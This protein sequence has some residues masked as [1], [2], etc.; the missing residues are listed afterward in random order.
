MVNKKGF[1]RIVEAS[2]AIILIFSVLIIVRAQRETRTAGK[3]ISYLVS[4]LLEE[5]GEN[6]NFRQKILDYNTSEDYSDPENAQII[7]ELRS[8]VE[9]RIEVYNLEHAVRIC[10]LNKICSLEPYPIDK[11]IFAGERVVAATLNSIEFSPRKIKIFLWK[12]N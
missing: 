11:E 1:I 9:P 12:K 4:P 10:D 7:Q 2:I 3:D 5:I 8:F 6:K